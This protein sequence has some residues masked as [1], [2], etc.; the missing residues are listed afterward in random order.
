MDTKWNFEPK[1]FQQRK[2]FKQFD[3]A[4]LCHVWAVKVHL[5]HVSTLVVVLHEGV[6]LGVGS[7][8]YSVADSI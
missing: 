2:T 4:G 8:K 7:K 1:D 5:D 3:Y 6:G